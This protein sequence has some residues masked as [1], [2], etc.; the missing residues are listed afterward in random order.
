MHLPQMRLGQVARVEVINTSKDGAFVNIGAE[1][2]IFM[3]FAEMRGKVRIGDKVWVQLY[4]DKSSRLAV[5]MAVE[6]AL[7]KASK[8][9]LDVQVGDMVTGSVYNY[10]DKGAFLFTTERYI[11]FLH[12]TEMLNERPKVGEEVTGRVT[13]L[14]EDGRINISLRPPKEDAMSVDAEAVLAI[15]RARGDKMPY[16]DDTSPEVIKQKFK[17]SKSAF[18]RAMGLLLKYHVVEQREGWTYL[19]EEPEEIK[20]T[21]E[22]VE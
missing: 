6:A 16:S 19:I 4:R 12:N 14:R 22:T 2:G 20:V 10:N 13:Y 1:R 18:K 15:L 21:D 8:P 5:T 3:P 17:L 7:V 9:A 11:A